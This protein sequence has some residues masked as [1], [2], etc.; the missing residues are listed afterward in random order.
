MRF[1][2]KSSFL[3]FILLISSAL[4][5]QSCDDK[6]NRPTGPDY[7]N[8]PEPYNI[9]NADTTYTKEG[10]VEIY[11]I[12]EGECPGGNEE[13]CTVTPRDQIGVR[14][15]GRIFEEGTIFEST[16]AD[17][18]TTSALITNL[19]SNSTQQQQ[20]Q[21]EGF[22]RG[23]LGMKE[24]EKRVIVV[25]PSLG[26]DNSRPGVNGMDLRDETLRYDVELTG[27]R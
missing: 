2:R 3:L 15:T 6:N 14:Y 24:G 13:F 4:I 9:S 20:A 27:I 22:R 21:I 1:F 26:Y 7:S 5:I 16:F 25:P 11:V 12:E 23:L 17:S 10:G 19:T 8:V 18:N